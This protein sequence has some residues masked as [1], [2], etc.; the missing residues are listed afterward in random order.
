LCAGA[1]GGRFGDKEGW[2]HWVELT[3]EV[4]VLPVRFDASR[5]RFRRGVRVL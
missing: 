2:R 4:A 3:S 1:G 5:A